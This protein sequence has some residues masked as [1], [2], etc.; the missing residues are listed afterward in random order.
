MAQKGLASASYESSLYRLSDSAPP[1]PRSRRK[2]IKELVVL[3]AKKVFAVLQNTIRLQIEFSELV[4]GGR[5]IGRKTSAQRGRKLQ[6]AGKLIKW[7]SIEY[8]RGYETGG[9][10]K[11][12]GERGIP[13]KTIRVS[14]ASRNFIVQQILPVFVN[15]R[16][17]QPVVLRSFPVHP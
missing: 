3:P 17:N 13:G 8:L 11:L 2:F 1:C 16:G 14:R 9:V 12:G 5:G 6:Q 7:N 15:Q 4:E 10:E